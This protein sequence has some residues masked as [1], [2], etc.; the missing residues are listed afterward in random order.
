MSA[1][2][3]VEGDLSDIDRDM[4]RRNKRANKYLNMDVKNL[5]SDS[6]D[7]EEETEEDFA[8]P[9]AIVMNTKLKPKKLTSGDS[10]KKTPGSYGLSKR[11]KH[12]Y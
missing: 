12:I 10:K 3:G 5:R 7:S 8:S 1:L 4:A 11:E 6:E 9:S 2:F